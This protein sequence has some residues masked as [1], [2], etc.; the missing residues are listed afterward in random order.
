MYTALYTRGSMIELKLR[1]LKYLGGE[2][3]A[4]LRINVHG[5]VDGRV[6][7]RFVRGTPLKDRDSRNLVDEKYS[8]GA[9]RHRVTE[10]RCLA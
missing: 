7:V 3:R 6:Y 10:S 8:L 1:T 9:E 2:L 4:S 5:R